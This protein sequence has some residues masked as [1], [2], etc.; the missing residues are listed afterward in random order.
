[1]RSPGAVGRGY[2]LCL[3]Q[4]PSNP[5]GALFQVHSS[6]GAGKAGRFSH[7]TAIISATDSSLDP[8]GSYAA[9]TRLMHALRRSTNS[10]A[11]SGFGGGRECLGKPLSQGPPSWAQTA[12]PWWLSTV[13]GT[14]PQSRPGGCGHTEVCGLATVESSGKA[15]AHTANGLRPLDMAVESGEAADQQR[16]RRSISVRV[17]RALRAQQVAGGAGA[18]THGTPGHRPASLTA[19]GLTRDSTAS[20]L[21]SCDTKSSVGARVLPAVHAY[22]SDA[23]ARSSPATRPHLA[24]HLPWPQRPS[25]VPYTSGDT[26]DGDASMPQRAQ[27]AQHAEDEESGFFVRMPS[28]IGGTLDGLLVDSACTGTTSCSAALL[29]SWDTGGR[30]TQRSGSSAA[31]PGS[32]LAPAT[33]VG[34]SATDASFTGH[35]IR[36]LLKQLDSFTSTSQFLGRF[37]MLGTDQRRRGGTLCAVLCA[38]HEYDV[39][40]HALLICGRPR[41][42]VLRWTML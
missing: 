41:C 13:T 6:R 20:T 7:A 31:R 39:P 42:A 16:R 40:R 9:Y 23:G 30:S 15:L 37:E 25:A 35:H 29:A 34:L 27:R 21:L 2:E 28:C 19:P 33:D 24:Q 5:N 11:S 32:T 3:L 17:A 36:V 8:S 22:A 18:A 1:M 26:L 12:R 14:I 38:H 4:A 10:A